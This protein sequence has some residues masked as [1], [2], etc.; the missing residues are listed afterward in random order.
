MDVRSAD[1][2]GGENVRRSSDGRAEPTWSCLGGQV[3][4]VMLL[5]SLNKSSVIN[6]ARWERRRTSRPHSPIRR[7]PSTPRALLLSPRLRWP[8]TRSL[9]SSP[10]DGL[11]DESGLPAYRA[12]VGPAWPGAGR[13]GLALEQVVELPF[14]LRR[15]LSG[16]LLCGAASGLSCLS[17]WYR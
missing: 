17:I 4:S 13:W 3:I 10:P 14:S 16:V 15:A 7:L 1:E 6:V 8:S 5:A 12:R 11:G 2:V 9:V